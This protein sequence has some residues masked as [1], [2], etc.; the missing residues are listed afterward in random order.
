M[1]HGNEY[2]GKLEHV[3]QGLTGQPQRI[4]PVTPVDQWMN[5]AIIQ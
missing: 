5:Q 4:T 3:W 1:I 2:T